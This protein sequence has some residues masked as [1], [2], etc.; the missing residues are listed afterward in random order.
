MTVVERP[1]TTRLSAPTPIKARD[2]RKFIRRA[3]AHQRGLGG[4]LTRLRPWICPFEEIVSRVPRHAEVLDAGCGT[5]I[6]SALVAEFALPKQVTGFDVSPEAISIAQAG[7]AAQGGLVEF[8]VM[9]A[10][11]FPPRRFDVVLCVDVLHHVPPARQWSFL[12]CLCRALR[13]GGLLLLK[14]ISPR[15]WWKAQANRVHDLLLA[16]QWVHYRHETRVTDYLRPAG[17]RVLEC[18]R[19]DRLWYSHYL[20]AW[21][22]MVE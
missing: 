16:R 11:H 5:G 20:I 12:D 17:G 18:R 1:S 2:V 10:F 7:R 3:Y 13:P 4:V 9:K 14:D 6:M 22:S 15:P 19:L 21:Q 8:A